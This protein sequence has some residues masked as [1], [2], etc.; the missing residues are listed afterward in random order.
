M[1]FHRAVQLMLLKSGR[2][3]VELA[4]YVVLGV[5]VGELLRYTRINRLLQ[6]AC[7]SSPLVSTLLAAVLG[8]TSP[9]C[10]YGTVPVVVQLHRAGVPLSPLVTF[11]S[12]SSLMNPQL[13][14]LTWGGISPAMALARAGAVLAFAVLLGTVLHRVPIRFMANA[15]IRDPDEDEGES[16]PN[17]LDAKRLVWRDFVRHSYDNLLFVTYYLVIGILLGSAVEVFVPGRWIAMAFQ[18][19]KWASVALAAVMGVPLYACGGGAIPLIRKLIDQGMSEGAA[20][21]FFIAGPATRITPLLA[22]GAVLRP[23]FI[24]VYVAG[25]LAYALAAGMLYEP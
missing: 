23:A 10:T 12:A 21:A 3:L 20:L 5:V 11:L 22:L 6:R 1:Y 25:L 16:V 9:L 14:I 7:S 19:G 15:R 18:P 8:V 2:M 17:R 13:F 4:P 24:G